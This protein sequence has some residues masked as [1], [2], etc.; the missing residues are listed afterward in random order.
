MADIYVAK[1]GADTNGG[2]SYS[3]AF[4]TITHALGTAADGDNIHVAGGVYNEM[5]QLVRAGPITV[6]IIGE[7]YCILDGGGSIANGF[8]VTTLAHQLTQLNIFDFIVKSFTGPAFQTDGG[9][10]G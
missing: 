4:L 6:N 3:D 1:D 8:E 5:V 2:T 10:H 9:F 7:G